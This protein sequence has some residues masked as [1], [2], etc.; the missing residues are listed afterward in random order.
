MPQDPRK[1]A[2]VL[3]LAFGK[4]RDPIEVVAHIIEIAAP[5]KIDIVQ[6]GSRLQ[7]R[8]RIPATSQQGQCEAGF[9][10]APEQIR[11]CPTVRRSCRLER[12]ALAHG[13]IEKRA[14]PPGVAISRTP[15]Q[16]PVVGVDEG[17]ASPAV[18]LDDIFAGEG[19]TYRE[20]I[21]LLEQYRP[22]GR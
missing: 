2:F 16:T 14:S 10:S 3:G 19:D 18:P 8:A 9:T 5:Q 20:V 22:V 13:K 17:S 7:I 6:I 4:P 1:I 15:L 21:I 12:P 11:P